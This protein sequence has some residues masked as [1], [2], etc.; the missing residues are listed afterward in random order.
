[1]KLSKVWVSLMLFVCICA[2]ATATPVYDN[3][4]GVDQGDSGW[5]SSEFRAWR[6]FDDFSLDSPALVNEI[7][8]QQGLSAGSF[9]GSFSFTIY[10]YLGAGELGATLHSF[11]L[12]PGSFAAT[13][14][15]FNS[16]PYGPFFD[17]SFSIPTIELAA[18]DYALSFY[19]LGSMDF[20]AANTGT[21][22]GFY[23][24]DETGLYCFPVC[25]RRGGI[26][27]RLGFAEQAVHLFEATPV[28]EPGTL[29]LLGLGIVGMGLARRRR[30]S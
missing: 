25:L 15:K 12:A 13:P 24:Q 17:V 14:I 6:I 28:P 5:Y 10:E 16:F 23:Q 3:G 30:K 21:G 11:E 9:D 8:F 19:G 4:V 1:M 7:W 22:N 29:A 18:G 26:P 20:R 27:F 2:R